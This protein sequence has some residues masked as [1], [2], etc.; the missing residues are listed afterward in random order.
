MIN[1]FSSNK[2]I[3][4][5]FKSFTK[6]RIGFVLNTNDETLNKLF[7][8][9]LKEKLNGE[10]NEL[11]EYDFFV[12]G[13]I[14]D[15]LYFN[16][17][18]FNS[19][20][21]LDHRKS[22]HNSLFLIQFED[23]EIFND[24]NNSKIIQHLLDLNTYLIIQFPSNCAHQLHFGNSQNDFIKKY[25][26]SSINVPDLSIDEKIKFLTDDLEDSKITV[27]ESIYSN[28]LSQLE[29]KNISFSDLYYFLKNIKQHKIFNSLNEFEIN[30]NTN[31]FFGEI[32]NSINSLGEK[33]HNEITDSLDDFDYKRIFRYLLIKEENQIISSQKVSINELEKYCG[34][35]KQF[36]K[37]IKIATSSNYEIL[38]FHE[39]DE[40]EG[41]NLI[42]IN[43]E[44]IE[45]WKKLR[46]ICNDER[47]ES[48]LVDKIFNLAIQYNSGKGDLLSEEQVIESNILFESNS[49]DEFWISKYSNDF[50]LIKGF[51][52][53]SKEFRS[54]IQESNERK[55]ILKLKKARRNIIVLSTGFVVSMICVLFAFAEYQ[56]ATAAKI[57]AE[58]SKKEALIYAEEAKKSEN[59]AEKSRI[60]AISLAK[61]AQENLTIA[62]ENENKAIEMTQKAFEESKRARG[63]ALIAKQNSLIAQSKSKIAEDALVLA[64]NNE[65]DALYQKNLANKKIVQQI[66]RNDAILAQQE[67]L[68]GNFLK[69]Y[70]IAKNAYKQNK[71]N[72]GNIFDKDILASLYKGFNSL[73]QDKLVVGNQVKKIQIGSKPKLYA[74]YSLDDSL[75]IFNDDKLIKIKVK[76]LKSFT[77][78]DEDNL[79]VHKSPNFLHKLDFNKGSVLNEFNRE[80]KIISVNKLKFNNSDHFFVFCDSKVFVLDQNLK[81]VGQWNNSLKINSLDNYKDHFICISDSKIFIIDLTEKNEINIL[82]EYNFQ[83]N[84]SSIS[85][86]F[87][88][89][90]IAIGLADG[91]FSIFDLKKN[92]P[93]LLNKTHKTKITGCHVIQA[94][95]KSVVVT[96]GM[97]SQIKIFSGSGNDWIDKKFS[98]I[99]NVSNHTSWINDSKLDYY[100]KNLL[101]ASA[102]GTVR[103]WPLDPETFLNY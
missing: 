50:N 86:V 51:I 100:N 27:N 91:N 82:R 102:D 73:Y 4:L 13:G 80:D 26:S 31:V 32:K 74:F 78:C 18:I 35:N 12:Y 66:A 11:K 20:N 75:S 16:T 52:L 14:D 92:N 40:W 47:I 65:D 19:K 49:F 81:E 28:Y 59:L 88:R 30:Q 44:F 53:K 94:N 46:I 62:K 25:I 56:A 58:N 85:S 5:F 24:Q 71:I 54:K 37:F 36:N 99:D 8:N 3:N 55:R 95:G 77:F 41:D 43:I 61:I 21:I 1:P 87:E 6:N 9:N 57:D 17:K 38:V 42:S 69:G 63:L 70:R 90:K 83:D 34:D 7:I 72:A 2:I 15:E 101:T 64:K 22:I 89:N 29:N 93:I 98:Q 33:F 67:Y 103:F 60:E 97:D 23:P 76:K 45:K 39:H 84:I 10:I 48:N 96:T 79:I 68:N